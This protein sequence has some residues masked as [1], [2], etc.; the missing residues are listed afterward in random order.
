MPSDQSRPTRA[1]TAFAATAATIVTLS[2]AFAGLRR[3][4]DV[5]GARVRGAHVRGAIRD[6]NLEMEPWTAP[7]ARS[8]CAWIDD[9]TSEHDDRDLDQD[10]LA[11]KRR[12]VAADANA[13]CPGWHQSGPGD[14]AAWTVRNQAGCGDAAANN[15]DGL[16]AEAAFSL[17]WA[18][19]LLS[20][21]DISHGRSMS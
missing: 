5:R 7:E 15:V 18:E 20:R 19:G 9:E 17:A 21:H 11:D 3:D 2:V 6:L 12:T 16:W 1:W 13:C 8:R 4:A 10:A 14:A